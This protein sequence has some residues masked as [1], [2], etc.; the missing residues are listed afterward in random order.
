MS[1]DRKKATRYAKHFILKNK[2]K[3]LDLGKELGRETDLSLANPQA[4]S[5]KAQPN[6]Y[7]DANVFQN[8]DGDSQQNNMGQFR[9]N[10]SIT[11]KEFYQLASYIKENYGINLKKEKKILLT[12]RLHNVLMQNGF[13]SFT[14]YYEYILSDKTGEAVSTLVN[15]ITT[16]HTFFMREAEHFNYFKETVLPY[17]K[18]TIKDKDLR[19][20]SAGCSTGEEAYTLAMIIDEFFGMDKSGW[21]TK[22]LATDISGKVLET[23]AKG[24]YDNEKTAVLTPERKLR[25]FKINDSKSSVVIDRIK[26]EVIFRKFNL[27]DKVYPFKRKF[28]VIF[29]RNVMIYFDEKTRTELINKFYD[30][31][32][33]GGYLFIGH[34]ETINRSKSKYKYVMPAV[35]R[36]E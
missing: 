20:W 30:A 32:E 24:I 10:F 8:Y 4:I 18:N 27:M 19:V 26:D 23:A 29:C 34:S 11:D 3:I 12:T 17:F 28:H 7:A 22:I 31:T 33:Y 14:E 5:S 15:Q 16:N 2:N 13:K 36:K 35:Y 9:Q 25:Y 1:E 21:D 6:S